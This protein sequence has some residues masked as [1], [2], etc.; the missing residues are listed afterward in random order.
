PPVCPAIAIVKKTL[1]RYYELTDSSDVY[2]IAMV[3]HP[4][5]KLQYFQQA[6]WEQD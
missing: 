3:L 2:H 1:N 6:N 5:H 4:R